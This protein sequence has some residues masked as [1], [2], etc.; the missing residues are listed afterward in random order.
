LAP[1]GS[2]S[3]VIAPAKSA[4]GRA[5]LANDPHRAYSAPSLRYL[6]HLSAPGLDVIGAG[7][8]ALPGVSLGHNGTI[9]FG[10]TIFN[11]DQEDLYVYELNPADATQYKYKD[12]W[13]AFRVIREVIPVKGGVAKE[14]ELTF[15]RHGPVA[16]VDAQKGRA[17]AVRSGWLETGMSPYFGSVDYMRAKDFKAFQASLVNW[18][19]PTLNQVY[20]DV[21]GNIGWMPSGLAPRR[22]NWDGLLPV[23]GD[24]R[25][26]WAG[27]WRGNELPSS[28]NPP[29]GFIATANAYNI[30]G[31]YP[32]R[33]RKLGFEWTN[34]SR[35]QRVH[36]VLGA[37]PKVSLE[38]SERLQNDILSIPARRLMVLLA[39]LASDD[40][41]TRRALAFLRGWDARLR[42]DSPQ[43]ALEEI[44]Q[45][46][47]LRKAYR[48]AVLSPE[49]AAA[50][51]TTDMNVM[52][53][54][55][56]TPDARFGENPV[57]KR[58]QLLLSTLKSAW[59]EMEKL[60][61]PE[62]A[63]WQWG[64]FHFN[65]NEHPFAPIV[66]DAM[67][68]RIN[69]GPI[70]KNGSEFTPS[71]S[72]TRATDFR[73]MNGPSVRIVLD[74]GNWDNSRAVNHPGQSGDPESP[75]YR[76]L[77]PLW[78]EG[79][80]FPLLYSRN[81]VERATERVIRLLPE[82]R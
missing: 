39:P 14:V 66:E 18:G 11:I 33:E 9:A 64:K 30:P 49:A 68:A 45:L 8:P 81:A 2:N 77:A 56:E 16:Y 63:F 42:A 22:P 61:G 47:H 15:T 48:E 74:V 46:R 76:D 6:V 65:L 4:T 31:D 35:H 32:A 50:L 55:L 58:D 7:E 37:L 67:R 36:E 23:P 20:A 21:K 41:K 82:S 17:Y 80:Y 62:P 24:G 71:Q 70:A 10:L 13:E 29:Q 3:W 73:Q 44:W 1:E 38:D 5:I 40:E 12:G 59:E 79:K 34:P 54:G 27:F 19:A 51:S 52:L 26:E 57:A 69:V 25:F 28:Y 72:L 60:Q 53:L 75:H 43:A 78:S